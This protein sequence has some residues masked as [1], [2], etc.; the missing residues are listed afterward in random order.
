MK[1]F[2]A[3]PIIASLFIT[4]TLLGTSIASDD[5][6]DLVPYTAIVK[7]C[8]DKPVGS[9]QTVQLSLPDGTTISG[10]IECEAEYYPGMGNLDNDDHNDHGNDSDDDHKDDRDDG[11]EDDR[12]DRDDDRDDRNDDR[13]NNRDD[14][15]EDDGDDDSDDHD[16]DDSDDS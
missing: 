2:L 4:P 7:F 8:A 1:N 12:D 13:D 11:H 15:N 14:D 3:K 6:N 16:D 5:I 10:T 9:L